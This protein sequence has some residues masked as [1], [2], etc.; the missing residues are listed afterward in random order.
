MTKNLIA[1][2]KTWHL[3]WAITQL[4]FRSN[5]LRQQKIAN[6]KLLEKKPQ[7]DPY[8][9]AQDSSSD[10]IS[11]YRDHV[12]SIF[13]PGTEPEHDNEQIP[14]KFDRLFGWWRSARR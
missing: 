8:T 4:S 6:Y 13:P 14:R 3:S 1:D 9:V 5:E 2:T 12:N 7:L 11:R 10:E